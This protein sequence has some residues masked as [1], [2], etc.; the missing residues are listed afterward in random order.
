V[1]TIKHSSV[2]ALYPD[3]NFKNT[4]KKDVSECKV[5]GKTP[6]WK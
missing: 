3:L 2:F 1:Y 5:L 4:K 6:L